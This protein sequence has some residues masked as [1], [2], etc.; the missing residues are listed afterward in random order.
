[1]AGPFSARDFI[2]LGLA[3]KATI[4][5]ASD[6]QEQLKSLAQD[7]YDEIHFL[8][9]I[10][11]ERITSSESGK[12][13]K[14][15]LT[16]LK[17]DLID[18]HE[19]CNKYIIRPEQNDRLASVKFALL[20]W[21]R[22]ND[23]HQEII[24][25]KEKVN[26]CF[27]HFMVARFVDM[28]QG[29]NDNITRRINEALSDHSVAA[30]LVGTNRMNPRVINTALAS[31]RNELKKLSSTHSFENN[32]LLFKVKTIKDTLLSSSSSR[33]ISF[34]G[35]IIAYSD[36]NDSDDAMEDAVLDSLR[37]IRTFS[38]KEGLSTQSTAENLYRLAL[39]LG[40]LDLR[41]DACAASELGA[42]VCRDLARKD[43]DRYT[44][45][46]ADALDQYSVLLTQLLDGDVRRALG[47]SE[48]AVKLYRELTLKDPRKFKPRL[49]SSLINLSSVMLVL[50]RHEDRLNILVESVKSLRLLTSTDPDQ[51]NPRLARALNNLADSLAT[52]KG[53]GKE[54]LSTAKEAVD[55][56]EALADNDPNGFNPLLATCLFTQSKCLDSLNC[57]DDAVSSIGMAISIRRDLTKRNP[58]RYRPLLSEALFSLSVSH[59]AQGDHLRALGA[60]EEALKIDRTFSYTSSVPRQT[61]GL[62]LAQLASCFNKLDH[63]NDALK[64]ME[65]TVKIRRE[66]V[67]SNP[68]EFRPDLAVSLHN[69]SVNLYKLRRFEEARKIIREAVESVVHFL[70][71]LLRTRAP[72]NTLCWK[73]RWRTR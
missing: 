25:I 56:A 26:V 69:L 53:R 8:C 3:I 32:Y 45:F 22:R 65:E 19:R 17:S 18:Y 66:L 21:K 43:A 9:K 61:L 36:M 51:F 39:T 31:A 5:Q 48:E 41:E 14:R 33:P 7:L 55:I 34:R 70:T 38:N 37:L 2:D 30:G 49:A 58:S 50:R 28:G 52:V 46:L 23:I 47:I 20:G 63:R 13:L 64:V 29:V 73:S 6:N 24:T 59:S 42:M 44:P 67:M 15:D 16:A 72:S 1:M 11:L 35:S 62:H 12:N 71:P 68:K 4:D 57:H 10:D 40:D 54:A 60:I 27:R